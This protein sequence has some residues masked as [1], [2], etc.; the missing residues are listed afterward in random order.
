[1]SAFPSTVE[2]FGLAAMEALAA[3]LR[4]VTRHLPVLRE[5]SGG[6]ALFG[7]GAPGIATALGDA[8]DRPDPARTAVGRTLAARHTR[9]AAT[10]RDLAFY[11]CISGAQA[12]TL[13]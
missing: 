3:G 9:E 5:V 8:L 12:A 4:L 1:V 11:H 13:A 7:A 10:R 2:G 6:A